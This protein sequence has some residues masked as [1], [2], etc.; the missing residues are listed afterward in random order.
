MPNLSA[1]S[2]LDSSA[3]G[4]DTDDQITEDDDATVVVNTAAAGNTNL[5]IKLCQIAKFLYLISN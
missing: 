4:D 5:K 2:A 3:H 1:L